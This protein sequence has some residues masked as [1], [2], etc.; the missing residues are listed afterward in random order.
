MPQLGQ[1]ATDFRHLNRLPGSGLEFAQLGAFDIPLGLG[2]P[3]QQ[4]TSLN[5]TGEPAT[6]EQATLGG[7]AL[8][9]L[10]ASSI[11]QEGLTPILGFLQEKQ[12][13]KDRKARLNE[14][15]RSVARRVVLQPQ[16]QTERPRLG[17]IDTSNL[18]E[19][20][21]LREAIESRDSDD[22]G[23]ARGFGP[24]GGQ[25]VGALA[26]IPFGP[27]GMLLGAFAGGKFGRLGGE[28]TQLFGR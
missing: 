19:A 3:T 27:P 16:R 11:L 7:G 15:E 9:G 13:G 6:Q 12:A 2:A 5:V 10:T 14:L 22:T 20:R 8:T 4:A 26:G 21:R 24:V 23:I 25:A 18:R 28:L 1:L 17:G